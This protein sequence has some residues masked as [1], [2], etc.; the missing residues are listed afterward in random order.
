MFERIA[1]L[2]VSGCGLIF[3]SREVL[4]AIVLVSSKMLIDGS[5]KASLKGAAFE[6]IV[7]TSFQTGVIGS[8]AGTIFDIT[9][10][11][12]NNTVSMNFLLTRPVSEQELKY[13]FWMGFPGGMSEEDIE[14]ALSEVFE[15]YFS[16]A[17][18]TVQ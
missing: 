17:G 12:E 14:S 4:D 10:K 9:L 7:I 15:E 11:T 8:K 2:K 13:S 3:G 18:C 16:S 6:G 5:N 1:S